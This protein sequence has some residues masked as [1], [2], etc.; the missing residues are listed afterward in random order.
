MDAIV[1]IVPFIM[2]RTRLISSECVTGTMNRALKYDSKPTLAADN[3]THAS[4]VVWLYDLGFFNCVVMLIHR[5]YA[6]TLALV[7]KAFV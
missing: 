7:S 2:K 4:I 3:S 5:R 6:A 1:P